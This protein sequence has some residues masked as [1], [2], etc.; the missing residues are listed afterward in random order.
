MADN[1]T[2][3]DLWRTFRSF[4]RTEGGFEGKE[5]TTPSNPASGYRRLYPK[6][7]GWYGLTSGGAET[8]LGGT[9]SGDSVKKT[10]NQA[11]HGFAAGN[12][13]YRSSGAWAKAK[14]DVDATAEVLGVVESV[15]GDA[16]VLVMSG[17]ITLSGLTDASV[18][19]LSAA[20]AGLLTT[21]EPDSTLYVSKPIMTAISTTVAIVNIMRGI[22]TA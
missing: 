2:I 1:R 15:N 19:F 21:T 13:V 7:D 4:L 18:Y 11:S 17:L 12:A 6:S 9:G 10:Y 5:I 14:A 16:F 8:A 22:R 3:S 20:T